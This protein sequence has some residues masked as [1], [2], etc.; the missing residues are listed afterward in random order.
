MHGV[1]TMQIVVDFDD[2]KRVYEKIE[3][4][5]NNMPI[6]ILGIILNKSFE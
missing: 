5:L 3:K 2:G 1:K 6:G 4:N